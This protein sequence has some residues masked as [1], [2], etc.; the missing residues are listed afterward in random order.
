MFL[1]WVVESLLGTQHFAFFPGQE[2]SL[3]TTKLSGHFFLTHFPLVV[4]HSFSVIIGDAGVVVGP[5]VI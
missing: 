5:S 2:M 4:L 1:N 3:S